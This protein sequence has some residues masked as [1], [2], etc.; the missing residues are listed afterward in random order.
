MRHYEVVLMIHPDKSDDISSMI[1]NYTNIIKKSNGKI[2][3]LEDW[4]RKQLAYAINKLQKVHYILMNLEI[5]KNTLD[6]LKS[7]FFYNENIIRNMIL[8]VKKIIIEPSPMLKLKEE[9]KDRREDLMN[10]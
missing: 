9:K 8:R 5:S 1:K 6:E 10:K 4:G 3:R 7:D 2:H